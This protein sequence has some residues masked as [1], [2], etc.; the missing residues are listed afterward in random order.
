VA[1]AANFIYAGSAAGKAFIQ[2]NNLA[3]SVLL[4]DFESVAWLA[5]SSIYPL[6]GL[7][8]ML[9]FSCSGHEM[10]QRQL[11]SKPINTT[12]NNND[13]RRSC[14]QYMRKIY[15]MCPELVPLYYCY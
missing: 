1:R 4:E 7:L 3:I 10:T 8:T 14:S 5:P 9:L 12:L 11:K 6:V 2:W 13:G 15:G